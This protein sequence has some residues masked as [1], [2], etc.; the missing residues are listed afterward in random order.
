[1]LS[2]PEAGVFCFF[3]VLL[4]IDFFPFQNF[5]TLKKPAYCFL[6]KADRCTLSLGEITVCPSKQL[7]LLVTESFDPIC[8]VSVFKPGISVLGPQGPLPSKK[9]G[10]IEKIWGQHNFFLFVF[11]TKRTSHDIIFLIIYK[12]WEQS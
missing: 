5:G 4:L 6:I 7:F 10:T 2:S 12:P 9:L 1:M 3:F 8:T 11:D